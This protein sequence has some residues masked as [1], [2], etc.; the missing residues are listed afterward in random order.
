MPT[1]FPILVLLYSAGKQ[2]K[3]TCHDQKVLKKKIQDDNMT[4]YVY[5]PLLDICLDCIQLATTL[6]VVQ[7]TDKANS[8]LRMIPQV[9]ED[10]D[11]IH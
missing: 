7:L 10:S 6:L 11:Y 4:T 1:P 3:V 8:P 2:G 9:S 5:N